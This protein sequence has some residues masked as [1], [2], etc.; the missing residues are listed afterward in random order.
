M[1]TYQRLK[2]GLV[3][4]LWQLTYHSPVS[5]NEVDALQGGN[6]SAVDALQGGTTTTEVVQETV[7]N[8]SEGMN[9]NGISDIASDSQ[10]K[11]NDALN[12]LQD[13]IVPAEKS[14]IL[15]EINGSLME[16]Q[17]ASK[18]MAMEI[19]SVI[20]YGL[21]FLANIVWFSL[22]AFYMWQTA[23]DCV[24]IITG[25]QKP[26]PQPSMP[27]EP[28]STFKSFAKMLISP[29]L[30]YLQVT[31]QAGVQAGQVNNGAAA[32]GVVGGAVQNGY[33][34][35]MAGATVGTVGQ[36]Q[37]PIKR[38]NIFGAYI[39]QRMKT[40]IFLGLT[41]ALF[42]SGKVF[43]IQEAAVAILISVIESILKPL[44]EFFKL[45]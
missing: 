27:Q 10:G 21:M 11:V 42:L 4:L 20:V 23:L 43:E 5:A 41:I 30:D 3:G 38:G 9:L 39:H 29:S 32:G 1:T 24:F 31:G 44:L 14:D 26:Q 35:P 2:L 22:T 33:N 45:A 15:S 28:E 8:T 6:S 34:Q 36:A 12:N 16:M 13:H 7:Q 18:P 37:Q 19:V 25:Y 40:L 17:Q